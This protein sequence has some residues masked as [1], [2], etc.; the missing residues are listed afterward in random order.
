MTPARPL[1]IAASAGLFGGFLLLMAGV[2]APDAADWWPAHGGMMLVGFVLPI[3]VGLYYHTFEHLGAATPATGIRVAGAVMTGAAAAAFAPLASGW[4]GTVL[5]A[6]AGAALAA[7]GFGTAK[8]ARAAAPV[9][10][11]TDDPLTKGDGASWKHLRLAPWFLLAAGA[12]HVVATVPA[13]ALSGR[14]AVA[15]VH[16]AG[17]GFLTLSMY[18]L[19]HLWIPRFS[20]VPAIAA[21]AIKG[22]L[23]STMLGIVLVFLGMLLGITGIIVAGG[24]FAFLGF[25]TYMGV[26]GANIMR[27]K[28]VTQRVTPEF[29][30]VPWTFAGVFWLL[31]GVLLGM[32]LNAVPTAL[33]DQ[34]AGLRW[35]HV[36]VALYGGVTMLVLGWSTRMFPAARGLQ[37]PRFAGEMRVS[38]L[39]MNAALLM[40]AVTYLQSGPTSDGFL[41]ST[42]LALLG[43][44]L[45]GVAMRGFM[46]SRPGADAS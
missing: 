1:L 20:G 18:G 15:A 30:Y 14:L 17:V 44:L 28:S 34:A 10:A 16:L 21:G 35:I 5:S 29:V 37:P 39:V 42:L 41:S 45:Y 23:H 25:F 2:M 46:S 12:A 36:H 7:V 33:A 22:E 19:G 43:L 27:N 24:A 9:E 8:A 6:I 3:V 13:L 31:S 32:F 11:V 26:L 38:F 40:A 4:V